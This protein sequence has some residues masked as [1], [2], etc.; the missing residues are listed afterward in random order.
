MESI[1]CRYRDVTRAILELLEDES[2][3]LD[4]GGLL[5]KRACLFR[6]IERSDWKT[7]RDAVK[8]LRE[9]QAL[10]RRSMEVA[11]ERQDR[12]ARQLRD[13]TRKKEAARA[14]SRQILW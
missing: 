10:E 1:Y 11:L 4:L 5:A 13:I 7:D 6:E 9:V 14:Y 8:I 12:M 3:D 2:S